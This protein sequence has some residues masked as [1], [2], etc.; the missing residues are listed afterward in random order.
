MNGMTENSNNNIS[1]NSY[2]YFSIVTNIQTKYCIS[3]ASS[4]ETAH[5]KNVPME[6]ICI[7]FV[8]ITDTNYSLHIP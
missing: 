2:K 6:N 4:G 7:N 3:K 1:K 8:Y 5:L